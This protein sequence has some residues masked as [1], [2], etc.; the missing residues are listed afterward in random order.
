MTTTE[1]P[2]LRQAG[3]PLPLVAIATVALFL[4]S[5]ALPI[6]MAGG[7]VYPSPFS[8]AATI[9]GYFRGNR[10]PVL[11]AALLQF[12]ASIPLAIY[13]A[14]ASVRL[15]RLGVRAPGAAIGLVGGVLASASMALSALFSWT[16]TRPEILGHT[17]L[18]RL[19]HDLAFIV[20]GPGFVVP[21]GLL[22]AG[23]AVPGLLARLLPRWLAWAGL[24]IAA[25]AMVATLAVAIPGL[26]VLL[27]LARFPS[28]VWIIVAAYVL[29]AGARDAS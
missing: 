3:P 6:A 28:F 5:L 14:T 9:V 22:V 18:I 7:D 19:V 29:P 4:A 25:I 1:G 27:P 20:G 21:S 12:A 26:A 16:L 10:V 8:S 17:E 11:L 23:I 2:R 13:A 24:V 15:N